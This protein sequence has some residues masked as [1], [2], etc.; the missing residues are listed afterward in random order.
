MYIYWKQRLQVMV[1]MGWSKQ[2]G[3]ILKKGR[4]PFYKEDKKKG[5]RDWSSFLRV[6]LCVCVCSWILPFL[7]SFHSFI[8]SFNNAQNLPLMLSNDKKQ[9]A[10][11][12]SHHQFHPLLSSTSSWETKTEEFFFNYYF[13]RIYTKVLI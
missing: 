7:V 4:D 9:Q 6:W 10:F 2:S 8:H 11:H 5:A 3:M 13:N 1:L 12:N